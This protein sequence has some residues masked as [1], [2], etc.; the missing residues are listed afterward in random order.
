MLL[1]LPPSFSTTFLASIVAPFIIGFIVGII[2]KSAVK[3]GLALLFLA[4]VLI[5]LGIISPNQ[6][7]GWVVSLI[8]SGSSI[9][10]KAEQIAGY[11][12][13]SSIT[14]L[15]GAALGFFKG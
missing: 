8:K 12:P 10:A 9:S 7:L 14:F 4:I 13:Y 5:A 11:L 2:I 15:L 1:I 6:V 3:I